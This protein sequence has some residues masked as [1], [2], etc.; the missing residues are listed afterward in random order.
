VTTT[1]RIYTPEASSDLAL[2][3]A[4]S[5]DEAMRGAREALASGR[6]PVTATTTT[7]DGKLVGVPASWIGDLAALPRASCVLVEADGSAR[8]PITAPR[9]GEP[10]IPPCATLVVAIV[11]VDALGAPIERAAH[12]PER[13]SAITRLPRS[14]SLDARAI[15]RVVLDPD[16]NT[17]GAPATARVVAL[18]NKVDDDRALASARDIAQAMRALRDVRVVIASLEHAGVREVVA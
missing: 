9:E 7:D 5:H 14:A 15:A 12:R 17:K 13:V 18:V 2:V 4:G 3:V 1:T 11:G 10:V 6:I 16:G 8:L